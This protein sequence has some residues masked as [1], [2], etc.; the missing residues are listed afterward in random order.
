MIILTIKSDNPEAE[1]SLFSDFEMI[2]QVVWT[3]DRNLARDINLKIKDLLIKNNYNLKDLQ[4]LIFYE[5]PGSFTGLRIGATVI[6]TLAYGQKIPI[7]GSRESDW[8]KKGI[9]KLK[10]NK[11]EKTVLPFYGSDANITTAKK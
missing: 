8:L 2:D 5:G 10:D 4:G 3:A 1:I 9:Q 7:V 6:N 11:N